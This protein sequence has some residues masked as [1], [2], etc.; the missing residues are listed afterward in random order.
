MKRKHL[1]FLAALIVILCVVSGVL[2]YRNYTTKKETAQLGISGQ[3]CKSNVVPGRISYNKDGQTSDT[4]VEDIVRQHGGEIVE[5]FSN[6]GVVFV[7]VPAG[8]EVKIINE[9]KQLPGVN[10]EQEK[11]Y[12]LQ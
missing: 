4:A 11:T 9:L 12:C 10:A 7:K 3:G 1:L 5:K 6:V 2:I 8:E